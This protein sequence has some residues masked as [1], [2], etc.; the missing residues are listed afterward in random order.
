[1]DTSNLFDYENDFKESHVKNLKRPAL[2]TIKKPLIPNQEAEDILIRL[3]N[4]HVPA[5]LDEMASKG[6]IGRRAFLV[7]NNHF[8]QRS[9]ASKEN[10]SFVQRGIF[11]LNRLRP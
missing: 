1:M 6:G 8:I 11:E 4:L 10:S 2:V 3:L 7:D 5:V 9:A